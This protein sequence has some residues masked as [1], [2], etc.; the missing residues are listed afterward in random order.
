MVVHINYSAATVITM[1]HQFRLTKHLQTE[2]CR[3]AEWV[4]NGKNGL[5]GYTHTHTGGGSEWLDVV[6]KLLKVFYCS[7]FSTWMVMLPLP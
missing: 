6:I 1:D 4:N 3:L 5:M 2:E 7:I